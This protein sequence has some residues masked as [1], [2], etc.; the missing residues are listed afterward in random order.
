MSPAAISTLET[1]SSLLNASRTCVLQPPQVTPVMV[2][3]YF[4]CESA[5]L[6]LPIR[7]VANKQAMNAIL[8]M[9]C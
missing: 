9:A 5:A 2:A 3:M 7:A 8:V 4:T 6:T 1:P